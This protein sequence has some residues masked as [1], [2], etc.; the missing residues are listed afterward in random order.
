MANNN[1]P[2]YLRRNDRGV[3]VRDLIAHLQT[4]DPTAR[5]VYTVDG[6]NETPVDAKDFVRQASGSVEVKL[7]K[8]LVDELEST[9][10]SEA[11]DL[12]RENERLE[13]ELK[14]SEEKLNK[15][16]SALATIRRTAS[17]A[18]ED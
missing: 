3:E 9:T 5:M 7:P 16:E 6:Y 4:L 11:D 2:E 10:S 1:D 13:C 15:L 14:D 18:L 17:E 12:E 8:E